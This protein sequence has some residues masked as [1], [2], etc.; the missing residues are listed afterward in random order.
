MADR[1]DIR[2]DR[3]DLSYVMA[4]IIDQKGNVIPNTDSIMVNFEVSGNGEIAGVGSGSPTDMASFQH[5]HRR[6][7]H[8]RC[9]AIVRPSG[10]E[11]GTISLTARAEGL[12]S[13]TIEITTK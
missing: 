1:T 9:M 2:A 3:N 8:G 13:S 6:S 7:W 5:P 12:E 4:E 10:N 11:T